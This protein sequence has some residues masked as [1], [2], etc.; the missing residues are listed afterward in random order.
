MWSESGLPVFSQN[1]KLTMAGMP[2]KNRVKLI[3]RPEET[4]IFKKSSFAFRVGI[5]PW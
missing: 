1:K 3:L 2:F 5:A 4:E